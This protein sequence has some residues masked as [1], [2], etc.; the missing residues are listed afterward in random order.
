[1]FGNDGQRLEQTAVQTVIRIVSL[2]VCRFAILLKLVERFDDQAV[3]VFQV[4]K[5][6][7]A[8]FL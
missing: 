4:D 7:N 6:Y 5:R 3:H 8:L 1:M 2:E